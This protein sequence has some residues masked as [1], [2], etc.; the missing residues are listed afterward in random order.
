MTEV[1]EK[2]SLAEMLDLQL[3]E[4]DIAVEDDDEVLD[5]AFEE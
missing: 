2:Q 4:D 5:L 1:A 3:E